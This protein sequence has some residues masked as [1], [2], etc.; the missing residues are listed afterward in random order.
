MVEVCSKSQFAL[1]VK[2]LTRFLGFDLRIAVFVKFGFRDINLEQKN[3]KTLIF[4]ALKQ[5]KAILKTRRL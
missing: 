4:S 5:S 2:N 1:T 3:I